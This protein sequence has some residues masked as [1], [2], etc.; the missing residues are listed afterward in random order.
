MERFKRAGE[1][2]PVGPDTTSLIGKLKMSL[3]LDKDWMRLTEPPSRKRSPYEGR[4]DQKLL[5]HKSKIAGRLEYFPDAKYDRESLKGLQRFSDNVEAAVNRQGMTLE[6]FYYLQPERAETLPA[7]TRAK[8]I[9]IRD[10]VPM[11]TMDTILEKV[12]PA[13]D[14]QKYLDGKYT[15]VQGFFSRAQDTQGAKNPFSIYQTLRLDYAPKP[16]RLSDFDPYRDQSI[17]VIRFRT[18]DTG[19][20]KIPF[21]EWMGGTE[22]LPY[23]NTGNG[24]TAAENG[25]IVPEFKIANRMDVKPLGGAELFEIYSDGRECLRAVYDGH[26]GIFRRVR[27]R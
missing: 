23:P 18:A 13:A 17:G 25:L 22:S 14:I 4:G 1:P 8:M 21:S 12:I 9:A 3:S 24:F 7:T 26:A 19:N 5:E 10:E 15:T 11:P 2:T 27:Q 16:G 6:E 20:I